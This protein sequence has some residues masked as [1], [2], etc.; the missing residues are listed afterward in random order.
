MENK[1]MIVIVNYG[2]FIDCS[3]KTLSIEQDL[4]FLNECRL[5]IVIIQSLIWFA[6]T[7]FCL[8][9]IV[10]MIDVKLSSLLVYLYYTYNSLRLENGSISDASTVRI[11]LILKILWKN[12]DRLKAKTNDFDRITISR[13]KSFHFHFNFII[14]F[15]INF[16]FFEIE[17]NS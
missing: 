14:C 1:W 2:L 9:V 15:D 3:L 12:N 4:L 17:G 6:E 11:M 8:L 7:N 5:T 10:A 16:N 13:G